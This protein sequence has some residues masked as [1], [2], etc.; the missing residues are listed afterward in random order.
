VKKKNI[1]IKSN[2]VAWTKATGNGGIFL[3]RIRRHYDMC[4]FRMELQIIKMP[5]TWRRKTLKELTV[6]Y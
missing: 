2:S 1:R 3:N 5:K 4:P 6:E